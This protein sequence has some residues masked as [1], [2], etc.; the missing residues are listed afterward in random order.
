MK[1][2]IWT[3]PTRLFHWMLAISFTLAF[4]LGGEEEYLSWHAALGVFIGMI[5]IFRIIQGFTG[6][7]YARFRDF[8]ITPAAIRLFITNMKQSKEN[9]PGHNPLASLIMLAIILTALVSA[10]SGMCIVASGETGLFGL[11]FNAGSN[12]EII[13]DFHEVVVHLFLILVGVH[14]TGLLADTILHPKNGT[15]FSIFSGYKKMDAV[16]AKLSQPQ[17]IF[18]AIW[19]AFSLLMLIYVRCYQP[20][21]AG[22]KESTEQVGT[23]EDEED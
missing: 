22:E 15:I 20:L 17:K 8:P 1:T 23:I 2:F 5:I 4:I 11:R 9:H 10:L 14:L 12:A 6:P 19:F 16:E 7:K 13:E 18:S 3:L 21:P